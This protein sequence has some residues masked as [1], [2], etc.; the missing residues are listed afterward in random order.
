MVL[1]WAS[2]L[3]WNFADIW[4]GRLGVS[5][6]CFDLCSCFLLLGGLASSGMA[7]CEPCKRE[8]E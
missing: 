3:V 8:T 2:V 6:V 7:F 1:T 5:P 4:A